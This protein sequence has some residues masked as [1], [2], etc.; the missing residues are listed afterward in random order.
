MLQT[1][2]LDELFKG[3]TINE[4]IFKNV[5]LHLKDRDIS[6]D[7]LIHKKVLN[8]IKKLYREKP[9]ELPS[10]GVVEQMALSVGGKSLSFNKIYEANRTNPN[11]LLLE[12]QKYLLKVRVEQSL[13]DFQEDYNNG[14]HDNSI[15]K[16]KDN[17]VDAIDFNIVGDNYP[18][19]NPFIDFID[20][21]N[22]IDDSDDD[23]LKVPFGIPPLD[24]ISKGGMEL[25][26]TALFI[27][28]SGVGK[29]TLLKF[30]GYM[31]S[32]LGF[33][34]LHF[35]LE[36][37][38]EE[39]QLKY[40]QLWTGL[41]Y[42]DLTKGY[43]G[44]MKPKT[45]WCS[46]QGKIVIDDK[47]EYLKFVNSKM[48]YLRERMNKFII[49]IVSFEEFGTPDMKAVDSKITEFTEKFKHP[50]HL[51]IVDSLDLMYP[52]D[53]FKYGPDI[54]STKMRIQNSAKAMKNIG[55][56]HKTRVISATQTGD[57]KMEDWNNEDFVID[58]SRSMGDKNVANPFSFVFSGNRTIKEKKLNE[59]RF[60]IDK[61]RDYEGEGMVFS[62]PTDYDHGK[63]INLNQCKTYEEKQDEKNKGEVEE[64]EE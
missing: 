8:V 36:G 39:A 58:R 4:E 54:Q 1:T 5:S 30:I 63:A 33:S 55:L 23:N 59:I 48:D 34:V 19:T 40:N 53:G 24:R 7:S 35:Q 12:L 11:D 56:R 22:N 43:F 57:I 47:L 64:S 9:D 26:S 62:L 15:L 10:I 21:I 17:L 20:L 38:K 49:E 6:K 42:Y 52:G 60:F 61:L 32:R 25:S 13:F 29:S 18:S 51:V 45:I 27:L 44:D 46:K 14:D 2:F 28:R 50:P 41:R 31:A 16:L 37:S 3:C